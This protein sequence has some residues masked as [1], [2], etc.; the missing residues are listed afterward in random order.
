MFTLLKNTWYF[1]GCFCLGVGWGLMSSNPRVWVWVEDLRPVGIYGHLQVEDTQSYNLFSPVIMITWWMEL[2]GNLPLGH[3]AL[4]FSISGMGSYIC[5][6]AQRRMNIPFDYPVMGHYSGGEVASP[7]NRTRANDM[8]VH[9]PIRKPP[10]L[11]RRIKYTPILNGGIFF[12]GPFQFYCFI[13]AWLAV[14]VQFLR[15]SLKL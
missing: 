14:S 2:G 8:S 13:F 7:A 15:S 11:P 1:Y 3:N 4:L 10:R 12:L 9:S 5:P 6:V